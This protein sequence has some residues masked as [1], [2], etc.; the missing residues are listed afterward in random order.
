MKEKLLTLL[1]IITIGSLSVVNILSPSKVFSSKEN[2]YLQQFSKPTIDNIMSNKFATDFEKYSS[3]QFI[4]RNKWIGL[5]TFSEKLLLKKDNERVYFGKNGYLFD[6]EKQI[7]EDQYNKNITYINDFYKNLKQ[8]NNDISFN[9]LFVPTKATVE[10]DKLPLYA[11]VL[12]EEILYNNISKDLNAKI[13][14]I[15]PIQTLED[16]E[17]V[18]YKTDH[19]WTTFGAFLA[20]QQLLNSLNI[21]PLSIENFKVTNVSDDFLGSAYRKANFYLNNPDTIERFTSK[22]HIDLN[23]TYNKKERSDSLYFNDFLDKADKY[24]Y[25]MGGDHGIVEIKTSI[26]NNKKII[27]VKDSFANAFIP[28][29]SNHYQEIYV[30]DTRYYN[31]SIIDL[32]KDKNIEEVLMLYNMQTYVKEKT[33]SKLN[34]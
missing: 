34:N 31:G 1:F 27:I 22:D 32:V 18:Y 10:K 33:L 16:N 30:I 26:K 24:S 29:L 6:V 2:R 12:D 17:D 9:A 14:M 13:K 15:N 8:V 23:V 25:F 4:M 21:E 5:K 3:D 20:Y 7:D 11:P 19:H 28:F